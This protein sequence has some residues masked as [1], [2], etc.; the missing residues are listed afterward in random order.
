[1][2]RGNQTRLK[3]S[4]RSRRLAVR[5]SLKGGVRMDLGLCIAPSGAYSD[6][7]QS[8]CLCARSQLRQVLECCQWLAAGEFRSQALQIGWSCRFAVGHQATD[9]IE[10]IELFFGQRP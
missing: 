9:Q 3:N 1:M 10:D 8:I 5:R 6:R 4:R 2:M 7:I